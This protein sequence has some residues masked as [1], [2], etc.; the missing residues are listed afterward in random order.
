M[1]ELR[2]KHDGA[3][4]E[5]MD[6]RV[7][8]RLLS[9]STVMEKRLRRRLVEHHATT[10]PRFDVL[11]ALDRQS[12]GMTMSELS[13][14]LLVSNGNVTLL[15]RQ[16]E[17]DGMVAS[18]VASGDARSSIVALT[19]EGRAHFRTLAESHHRWVQAML[20][21]VPRDEL[22]TLYRLLALVKSSIAAERAPG[23][24]DR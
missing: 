13:R 1:S 24:G 9:C 15:V 7:W 21:G 4:S 2:E 16:L 8:L 20:A 3:F 18:R 6:V 14:A 17:Q 12:A 11:A 5:Q 10:L 23:E 19:E 22:A